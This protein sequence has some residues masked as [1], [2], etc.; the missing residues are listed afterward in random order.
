M[1]LFRL[2]FQL[3]LPDNS[4]DPF[5]RAEVADAPSV[6]DNAFDCT[7]YAF[8]KPLRMHERGSKVFSSGAM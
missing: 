6:P 7:C 2:P 3:A 4:I 1:I 8:P 5:T